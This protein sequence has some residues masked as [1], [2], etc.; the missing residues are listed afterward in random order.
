MGGLGVELP[1]KSCFGS[2]SRFPPSV[3]IL[4]G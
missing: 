1:G 4:A 3:P 2:L